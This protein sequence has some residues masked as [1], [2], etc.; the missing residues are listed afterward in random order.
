MED[1]FGGLMEDRISKTIIKVISNAKE[2][3]ETR[4]IEKG[5][6]KKIRTATR[7]KVLY[8]LKD[9][10]GEGKIKGKHLSAGAKGIWIW[11]K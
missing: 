3:L 4:E 1:N 6:K 9:L 2:P 11:W 7:T 8:R 5:V 10:R